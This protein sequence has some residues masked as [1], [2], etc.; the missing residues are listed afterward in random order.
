MAPTLVPLS[1]TEAALAFLATDLIP[2]CVRILRLSDKRLSLQERYNVDTV[3]GRDGRRSIVARCRRECK[4]F[5]IKCHEISYLGISR[6][7]RIHTGTV[8][9]GVDLL[10]ANTFGACIPS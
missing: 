2:V 9:A 7:I 6:A 10:E 4:R 8:K 1:S 5:S 3:D